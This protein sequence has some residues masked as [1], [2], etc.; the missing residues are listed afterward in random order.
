MMIS[1]A[2]IIGTAATAAWLILACVTLVG[3]AQA[4]R[5]TPLCAG[6]VELRGGGVLSFGDGSPFWRDYPSPRNCTWRI[7]PSPEE[8]EEESAARGGIVLVFERFQLAMS[9]DYVAVRDADTGE[10]LAL[11]TGQLATPM[12]ARFDAKALTVTFVSNGGRYGINDVA[13]GKGFEAVAISDGRCFRG[14][15]GSGN[16]GVCTSSGLCACP[17]GF[18]G[19][20]CSIE[21]P[22]L[23][24]GNR[25]VSEVEPGDTKFYEVRVPPGAA[26]MMAELAFPDG[27]GKAKPVLLLGNGTEAKGEIPLLSYNR[28]ST[29][30]CGSL[31][32]PGCYW[33]PTIELGKASPVSPRVTYA[34]PTVDYKTFGALL[35]TPSFAFFPHG[36]VRV[37]AL[38][39]YNLHSAKDFASSEAKDGYHSIYVPERSNGGFPLLTPGRWFV[40]VM[41]QPTISG[42]PGGS[43]TL[44]FDLRVQM[45]ADA[46]DDFD[47]EPGNPLCPL[48]CSGR[49]K[50]VQDGG[51]AA[52]ECDPG[53]AGVACAS[54]VFTLQPGLYHK[55]FPPLDVGAWDYYVVD[56]PIER[57]SEKLYVEL[58]VASAPLASP[59]LVVSGEASKDWGKLN[60]PTADVACYNEP[61]GTGPADNIIC[62]T[63]GYTNGEFVK[64]PTP[65]KQI[66]GTLSHSKSRSSKACDKEMPC[67]PPHT[68]T[69]PHAH[70][71]RP[72]KA[73]ISL[74]PS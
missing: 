1:A 25:V 62:F 3:L 73:F 31:D 9:D 35:S 66:T 26:H 54:S 71:R 50:C 11:Y 64:E 17:S 4:Q 22:L 36:T 39:T 2:R 57:L 41:N 24:P 43:D 37:P 67:P 74:P 23:V 56:V 59:A 69:T 12:A 65:L 45:H 21:V 44:V 32:N 18:M 40:G 7:T 63:A 49:G 38:P 13:G 8:E 72:T 15:A 48:Q 27:I 47:D 70:H 46:V 33:D 58:E 29:G 6:E 30:K 60:F 16:P 53:F 42:H 14:C 61:A 34:E 10:P 28:E 51:D 55:S 5:P 19:A 52:C 20:D 68:H